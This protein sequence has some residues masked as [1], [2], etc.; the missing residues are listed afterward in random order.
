MCW[1]FFLAAISF[2]RSGSSFCRTRSI[3]ALRLTDFFFASRTR[4]APTV[5]MSR[6]CM[7]KRCVLPKGRSWAAAAGGV[8]SSWSLARLGELGGGCSTASMMPMLMSLRVA[9]KSRRRS[10]RVAPPHC[11]QLLAARS[12]NVKVPSKQ[13]LIFRA[14]A[15]IGSKLSSLQTVPPTIAV[16]FHDAMST[17]SSAPSPK[18]AEEPAHTARCLSSINCSSV[19]R[20]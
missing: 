14:A 3:N 10:K 16:W 13:V 7:R 20:M 15:G 9:Q 18:L 19:S 5:R 11:E 2:I 12:G 8:R 6:L 4:A 1:A 17:L